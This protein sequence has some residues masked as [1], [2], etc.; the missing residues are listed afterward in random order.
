MQ[1]N[2]GRLQDAPRL[3]CQ[4]LRI[5]RPGSYEIDFS[6]HPDCNASSANHL[7]AATQAVNFMR[8]HS[9]RSLIAFL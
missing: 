6:L 1:D 5:A 8:G 3:A 4:Q 2:I 7:R 9:Y